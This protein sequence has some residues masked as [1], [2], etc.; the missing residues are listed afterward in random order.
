MGLAVVAMGLAAGGC[1]EPT[2]VVP[3][4]PLGMEP[5]RIP[6]IPA[7]EG[8]QAVG[9]QPAVAPG[10]NRVISAGGAEGGQATS[11]PTPVGQPR[12]TPSGLTYVT[13]KEGT[14]EEAKTGQQI[15]MHYT[16][17]LEDGTKFDSSRDRNQPFPVRIGTGAVI[18]GWDEGVPGM[19]VG[20]QRKLTI[21]AKL[22]YG[23]RAQGDKIPANS[24][25][26][27]DVELLG[28]DK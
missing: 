28:I 20:E 1:H 17:T 11:P 12:T 2:D 26:I 18:A 5:S 22:G 13:T 9:E 6:N 4:Y 7:G 24:T 15:R 25:L 16:G 19:K 3:V 10:Q 27:F 14:G 23:D 8:A 21:P